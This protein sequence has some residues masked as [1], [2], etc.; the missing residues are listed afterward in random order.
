[1]PIIWPSLARLAERWWLEHLARQPA[2]QTLLNVPPLCGP[3]SGLGRTVTWCF[4]RGAP[5][6][7]IRLPPSVT[8]L[9]YL[10]PFFASICKGLYSSFVDPFV[11]PVQWQPSIELAPIL[12]LDNSG[13]RYAK[14]RLDIL[15][16]KVG[17]SSFDV[18]EKRNHCLRWRVRLS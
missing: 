11:L 5:S 6:C 12:M 1:M 2:T 14:R 9:S 16:G 7:L 4:S 10:T 17:Y 13:N 15:A 3:P 18:A 8:R